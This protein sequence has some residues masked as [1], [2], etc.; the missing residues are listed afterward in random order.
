MAKQEVKT[1]NLVRNLLKEANITLSEQGSDIKALSEA[2]ST[3]SKQGSGKQGYPEFC[4]VVK[5]FVIVIEN[6]AHVDKHIKLDSNKLISLEPSHVKD[7]AINGALWYARHI[8]ANQNIYKKVFAIAVSGDEKRHRITPLFVDNGNL[9]KEPL[10]D[11]Q[12]FILL[13][14]KNIEEFYRRE[15]LKEESKEQTTK[16]EIEKIAQRL[17]EDLRNYGALDDRSKPLVVAGILL[18]LEE[19]KT[20]NYTLEYLNN[21]TVKPDGTKL[22]EL[23]ESNLKRSSLSPQVKLDKVLAQFAV[24]KDTKKINELCSIVDERGNKLNTTPLKAYT[25]YIKE[26]IFDSIHKIKNSED[27]LGVFYS[28]FMRFSGGDG[29]TL[30]IV[31]TPQHIT[32]LFCELAD[33]KPSDRVLDPCCGTAGFLI[34]AMDYMLTQ[35]T[36]EAQKRDIRQHQLFG[37][38]LQSFMF[39]VATANMVLRGDGKSNLY[40]ED[41]LKQNP[42]KLQRDFRANIGFMNPP[43]SQGKIDKNLTEIAFSEHLL[44]SVLKGGKV[45]VIIP[46]SAVTGKSKEEKAIKANILKHHTLEGVITL[47]KNTFYGIGTN[48]CIAVFTA[49]IPHPKDKLCKFINFENDGFEVQKHRGLVKS[50][51]A[52]DKK[53]HLLDV[54]FERSKSVSKFC[55]QTSIEADDEWLHSFYYFNDEIPQYEEF[56]KTMADYLSFEFNMITHG[57]GYLFGLDEAKEEHE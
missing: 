12:T 26:H 13:N 43:Y 3:A 5:D 31:L 22:Y 51:S 36:N 54:W 1:D 53:A 4:G 49:G 32:E 38:E 34:T 46:Q 47:N 11:I 48:P 33:L 44:N 15:V 39:A 45:V 6:K 25:H 21:D 27:Y 7:Y 56:E 42:L 17:H 16:E 37:F 52:K 40:D 14:E 23:I 10:E 9:I 35:S 8:I 57:R 20:Q 41:F 50:I 2:L 28:E 29:Q 55:V 24:I 30:G 18:A 19:M